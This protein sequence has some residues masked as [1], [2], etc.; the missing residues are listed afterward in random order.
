VIPRNVKTLDDVAGVLDELLTDEIA[1]VVRLVNL[2]SKCAL[3]REV[4][5]HFTRPA[6]L[7]L[8]FKPSLN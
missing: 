2:K 5:Q 4:F 1:D 8:R 7:L 6:T 3:Y